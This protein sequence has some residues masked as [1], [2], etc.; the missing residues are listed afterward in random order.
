M[1]KSIG[2]GESTHGL[3]RL[4]ASR[5]LEERGSERP[6]ACA[7]SDILKFPDAEAR[8]TRA[9][10]KL[11]PASLRYVAAFTDHRKVVAAEFDK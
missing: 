6:I 7:R 10:I 8:A 9:A 4:V 2:I 5:L 11:E 1:K 3:L